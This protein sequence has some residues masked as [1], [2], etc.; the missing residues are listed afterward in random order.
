MFPRFYPILD[1]GLLAKRGISIADCAQAFR[2]AG[3]TLLQYRD[4]QEMPQEILQ[5]AA[6][7][8]KIFEDTDATLILDDRANIAAIAGWGGVHVGQQDMSPDAARLVMGAEAW[9][10]LSTHNGTQVLEG[11]AAFERMGGPGYLAIGPVF[12]TGSKEN[13][14]P[15]VG[16]E[17]VRRARGLT[18]LPLVAIG[19]ITRESAASVLE[20]GADTIAVIS[21]AI[22]RDAAETRT[23]CTEWLELLG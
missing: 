7:I 5:N 6:I 9:I 16:L 2:D 3:V 18:K 13:P 1:A 12:A 14:D 20:A 23:R 21:D 15:V 17:G 22:G 19:G 8:Q 10:G 4:K 11:D